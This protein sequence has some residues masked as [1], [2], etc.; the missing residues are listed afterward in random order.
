MMRRP[1]GSNSLTTLVLVVTLAVQHIHGF[2][3]SSRIFSKKESPRVQHIPISPPCS[4]STLSSVQ[5]PTI[6]TTSKKSFTI[7]PIQRR[8]WSSGSYRLGKLQDFVKWRL[9]PR[10]NNRA[11]L[12]LSAASALAAM[13][14]RPTMAFAM[15]GGMGGIKGPIAPMQRSV[16]NHS[17]VPMHYRLCVHSIY[18]TTTCLFFFLSLVVF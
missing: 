1:V 18:S 3:L 16:P 13:V 12:F 8:W 10:K 17:F 7:N 6:T 11:F 14:L 2:S 4:A 15:G 9:L 5:L